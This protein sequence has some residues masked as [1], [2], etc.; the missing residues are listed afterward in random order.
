MTESK[1]SPLDRR[2][3]IVSALAAGV[4]A[5][6]PPKEGEKK[7]EDK[8]PPDTPSGIT[9]AMIQQAEW[10]AGLSLTSDERKEILRGVNEDAA[11]FK[12]LRERPIDNAVA[13][14]VQFGVKAPTPFVG[15][16]PAITATPMQTTLP[17]GTLA[18]DDLSFASLAQLSTLIS[19]RKLTSVELTKHYLERLKK[20]NPSLLCVV[21][22][23]EAHALAQAKQADDEIAAGKYRG[24]LHGIPWGAKDLI[25]YP[26]FPTTWGAEPFKD[27]VLE[28]KATVA[29]KLDDAGAVL[30]AKLTLGAL[31]MGDKWFGGMTRSPWNPKIG[32]SGSSAGSASA[33][34][35]G[36]VGFAIGSETLG[37]IVSPCRRCGATGLRPTFG[38]VSRHGCMALSWSMDKIGPIARTVE[39]CALVFA[40][41]TGADGLDPTA[42]TRPFV[43][44][45]PTPLS[46]IRVGYF[47]SGRGKTSDADLDVLKKLGVQLV[48][49]EL[50]PRSAGAALMSILSVE[51]GAAFDEITRK[52]ITASLNE[53]PKIFRQAQF[54]TGV[55][56]LRANRLR[57]QLCEQ[58]N[59]VFEN[60]D[61]YIGGDDLHV[62]NLTGHPTVVMPHTFNQA[63]NVPGSITFTGNLFGEDKL[64]AVAHAFQLATGHHL[65]RPQMKA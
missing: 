33:S 3:L 57:S 47:K 13:P 31:A 11:A 24:P 41:I 49:I 23:M 19:T 8:K 59:K 30:V 4:A 10:T 50:P 12:R 2:A 38:R 35:G 48:P 61:L 17:N 1:P 56:Y 53:W 16:S 27:R 20:F 5:A 9:E 36:L 54:I 63:G 18:G 25:S 32:S 65:K 15:D 34:A 64:L 42:V 40:A 7:P 21:T 51:A 58:M 22:M 55:E 45:C 44:P 39:D 6:Q 46:A 60:I 52:K 14:A 37:S 29:K 28:A 26:G 43:W 62:C